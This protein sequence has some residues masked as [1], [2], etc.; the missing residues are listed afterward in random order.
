[1][2]H[3]WLSVKTQPIS[4]RQEPILQRLYAKTNTFNAYGNLFW[5]LIHTNWHLS[6]GT[7]SLPSQSDEDTQYIP[8]VHTHYY[9]ALVPSEST[10]LHQMAGVHKID[11]DESV[12]FGYNELSFL[13]TCQEY[14][15]KNSPTFDK[16]KKRWV[17][18][19]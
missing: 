12:Y 16:H 11:W 9:L 13:H 17:H 4:H 7:C 14:E 8:Y 1:M 15:E 3:T 19:N 10:L 2:L 18:K 5:R 6:V